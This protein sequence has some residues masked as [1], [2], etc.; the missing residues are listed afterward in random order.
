MN[1]TSA[2]LERDLKASAPDPRFLLDPPSTNR[3]VSAPSVSFIQHKDRL[4]VELSDDYAASLA[5]ASPAEISEEFLQRSR[6]DAERYQ[7]SPR[8]HVN[9]GQA[10]LNCGRLDESGVEF[11]KALGLDRRNYVARVSLAKVRVLQ[12]RW[13]DAEA[14]YNGL[15][16]EGSPDTSS[17]LNLAYLS[18]RRGEFEGALDG[19]KRVVRL[20]PKSALAR[21]HL[22]LVL[23]RLG[24]S[25]EAIAQLRN[26]ARLDVRTPAI[27]QA[28]G[29]AYLVAGNNDRAARAF[30]TALKLH[31]EMIEAVQG[32]SFVLLKSGSLDEATTLLVDHLQRAPGDLSSREMLAQIYRLLNRHESARA[33]LLKILEALPEENKEERARAINNIGV[34]LAHEGDR[35]KAEHLLKQSIKLAPDRDPVPYH[36]LARIYL[37]DG[38]LQESEMILRASEDKF[39]QDENTYLLL[40]WCFERQGRFEDAVNELQRALKKGNSSAILYA[41]LGS[42]LTDFVRDIQQAIDLLKEGLQL[43]PRDLLLA[44]NLAYAYL[45]SGQP[46]EAR[47]VL[48]SLPKA[49]RPVPPTDVF[50]KAT[51]GLLSLSEGDLEK[52]RDLYKSAE[53]TASLYGNRQLARQVRQKMH[54]EFARAYLRAGDSEAASSHV[55]LGLN[56]GDVS[57]IYAFDLANLRRL[58]GGDSLETSESR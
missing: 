48:E 7:G 56:E 58:L 42:A 27:Y 17:M 4:G 15:L 26:A 34:C 9:L 49:Q 35:P 45:M 2:V 23:L 16:A 25:N 18:I 20:D 10:L 43:Y 28:L 3:F 19:L 52:A 1:I 24:R 22:G 5:T 50:L 13:D 39:P 8:A 6:R 36:N 40:M 47:K 37:E 53:K 41:C 32:L 11:E 31:P 38:R 12:G 55:G 46:N 51:W 57:K 54:L 30:K 14:I 21:Y 44:N 29:V 33:Q